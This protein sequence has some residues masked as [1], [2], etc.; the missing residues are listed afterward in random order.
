MNIQQLQ[1]PVAQ[2]SLLKFIDELRQE[3]GALG[4]E[5]FT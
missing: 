4:G 1:G 3:V 2:D 5:R